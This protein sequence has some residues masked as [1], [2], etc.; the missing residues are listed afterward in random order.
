MKRLLA[1]ALTMLWPAVASACAVCGTS[2]ERNR[3]AY[4]LMTI[5]MSLLPLGLFAAGG[6]WFRGKLR[7]AARREAAVRPVRAAVEPAGQESGG[8]ADAP[9]RAGA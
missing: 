1:L 9:G 6:L 5:V 2:T 8:L 4:L 3:F 7:Q